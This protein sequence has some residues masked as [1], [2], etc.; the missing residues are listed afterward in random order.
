MRACPSCAAANPAENR[1]CGNCGQALELSCPSCGAP[2]PAGNRFCGA[3]GARLEAPAGRDPDA[4]P[5]TGVEGAA[6]RRQLTVIHADLVG[7]TE[8]SARLDPE[9]YRDA[10]R[11]YIAC[12]SQVIE[13]G[14]GVIADVAGD[15]AL[16]FF[17]Y[18]RASEDDAERAIR[19]GMALGEEVG[20][21]RPGGI[22]LSA[23][24]GVA[25]GMV[26]VGE[27]HDLHGIGPHEIFG[28]TPNLAARLQSVA[29]PGSVVVCDTTRR[30]CPNL[31]AYRDLEPVTLKGF[32][33]PVRA[34]LVLSAI[35]FDKR[36]EAQDEASRVPLLGREEEIDL[37]MRRWR[38]AAGGRGRVVLLTGEPGIG[39]S[40][41][42][43][44]VGELLSTETYATLR[45]FCSPHHVNSALHPFASAIERGARIR[46]GDTTEEKLAKVEA[47]FP[48]ARDPLALALIADLLAIPH[49]QETALAELSPQLRK[50]RTFE[51]MLEAF[52]HF[53]AR[54]PV[55]L[56][57][58]D[59]HWIDPTS[60]E[61]LAALV[62]R[63]PKLPV[64][65]LITARPEFSP[66]WPDYAHVSTVPLKRLDDEYG[67][68]LVRR[69]AGNKP[70]PR[71]I[72]QQ[73]LER[74][75]GVPLFAEE[76][77]RT[78]MESELLV[79]TEHGYELL[80]PL[81]ALSIPKTLHASLLARLDR[82]E[83]IREIAQIGAALGREFSFGLLRRVSRRDPETLAQAL[84]QL[85]A[86]GLIVAR[87]VPPDARYFF[88]HALLR[89]AAYSSMLRGR[90]SE[91]H[92][93]VAAALTA[94]VPDIAATEP[95][96]VAYHLT[97][98]GQAEEAAR[99]WLLA[100]RIAAR[101]SANLEAIAHL[102]HGLELLA[103]LEGREDLARLELDLRF[104]LGPC[105]I[106][107]KGPAS[108]DSVENFH[109]ARALCSQLGDPE[110][111]LQVMFWIATASV[112]RGELAEA[113]EAVETLTAIAEARGD[114]AAL[115]NA[116]RGAGM[117][118][119]FMGRL[120]EAREFCLKALREFEVAGEAARAAATAAGQD[121]GVA[122]LAVISWALWALGSPDEALE[123]SI[124][125]VERADA[126]DHS[127]SRA[128]AHYYNAVLRAL[129]GEH[130]LARAAAERC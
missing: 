107:A 71:P 60:L 51:V 18:P 28:E 129:R 99:Y 79:E 123:K 2:S 40:R 13:S 26:V 47:L 36:H 24:V 111:Y 10:M 126:V 127:H 7:S 108:A 104:A 32:A 103:P 102:T 96:T 128:Y 97:E 125:A 112:I 37:L 27:E 46:R 55:F 130:E 92:A 117:I 15:G 78:V 19:V 63:V 94:E 113:A 121:A 6:Q 76:L 124:A 75:D 29:P 38:D 54:N 57:F 82:L 95:E 61:L 74:A 114:Q 83:P 4:P 43:R 64:L 110:E 25:T 86:A 66:P 119:L 35:D 20:A 14:G 12:V 101:R 56:C 41:I 100:G 89:D 59:A 70:L 90:R 84:D 116:R 115:L 62:E 120:A 9:E 5:A 45:Y 52:E 3:C 23:R 68:A 21:L 16:A 98:A 49:G 58:E 11:S 87:G 39:K 17:G 31:F 8:M 42:M 50:Q 91:L 53:A 67:E 106:A 85:A 1:F 81:P 109:R 30:L 33:G 73:I 69:I 93:A 48:G 77:T 65:A 105:L 44:A 88:R 72:V 122:A 80:G 22:D 34:S 118:A